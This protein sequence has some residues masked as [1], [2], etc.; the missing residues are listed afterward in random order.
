MKNLLLFSTIGMVLLSITFL[1]FKASP[2]SEISATKIKWYTLEE[3]LAAQEKNDKK[4]F[5][6]MY[7]DWCKW[8]KVMDQKTFTDKAVIQYMNDNFYAVKFN[9]EQ[10]K[11]ITFKGKKYEFIPSGRRGIHGLAFELMEKSASY[12]SFVLLDENLNN[13]GTIKGYKAPTPFM[14]LLKNKVAL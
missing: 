7:T 6:D 10:K 1:G 11:A 4:I 13:L 5:I 2:T 8:C 3:A 9:A 12:P 14:S